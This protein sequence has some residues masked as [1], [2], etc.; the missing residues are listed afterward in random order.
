MWELYA[1]WAW[2]AVIF[3]G[4]M[5]KRWMA[6]GHTN[7]FLAPAGAVPPWTRSSEAIAFYVIAIGL[8][9]CVWAGVVSDRARATVA[10]RSRVTIVSMAVSGACCVLAAI[11]FHHF[12]ALVGIALIW[13]I[14][15]IADSAQFSAIVSEVSDQSYVGTALTMQTALGFLLTAFSI[16][17]IAW[18]G[19][20]YGWRWAIL[21]MGI[22]PALGTIAMVRLSRES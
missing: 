16:R 13:G 4:P 8:I 21:A 11:F 7:N 10:Q 12:W 2:I 22:G 6:V 20:S 1:M 3:T 17:A 19:T 15:I 9:G 18:V 5:L 14:A